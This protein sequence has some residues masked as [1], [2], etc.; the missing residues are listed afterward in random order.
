[1]STFVQTTLTKRTGATTTVFNPM[2]TENQ[3]HT[4]H[5][6]GT[7]AGFG[8]SMSL[9]SDRSN[10]ARR[11]KV[12]VV[13]PQLDA[14]DE[15]VLYKPSGL[16]ELYI[17]DGTLQTDVDDIVGYLNALTASGLTNLNSI[18]VDGVGVF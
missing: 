16:I 4:L 14:A 1:M 11:T 9:Y 5:A 8:P 7:L 10:S 3:W 15:R 12:R 2:T 13:I 18:L 6:S 17:P